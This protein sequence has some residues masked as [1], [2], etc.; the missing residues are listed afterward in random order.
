[1]VVV[2]GSANTVTRCA[3]PCLPAFV[4]R[5]A[6]RAG[7]RVDALGVERGKVGR[8]DDV[9]APA[10][11]VLEARGRRAQPGTE[12][13][14]VLAV[15]AEEEL[16][17]LAFLFARELR[18]LRIVGAPFDDG[19]RLQH[20][21]VQRAR[22]SLARTRRRDFVLR[23]LQQ[24]RHVTADA[25]RERVEQHRRHE[26]V[27]VAARSRRSATPL[28]TGEKNARDGDGE[29]RERAA[30]GPY[31]TPA[32]MTP[33]IG[34]A[35]PSVRT[36]ENASF[37][38]VVCAYTTPPPSPIAAAISEL[39]RD[40]GPGFER[41]RDCVRARIGRGERPGE[42]G[43]DEQPGNE[44]PVELIAVE[45]HHDRHPDPRAPPECGQ[46][47]GACPAASLPA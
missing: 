37:G 17:Q 14:R 25:A 22:D 36:L 6:D 9:D 20:A 33:A 18:E 26:R 15:A 40:R 12:V 11:R 21:V 47:P 44:R 29:A 41:V 8:Q 1:M 27:P 23:A 30:A 45:E 2:G 38:S 10:E 3:C 24:H 43:A 19:E 16:A 32:V 7:E 39:A 46:P 34:H 5:F 42:R 31:T 35:N 4:E 13:G 28:T